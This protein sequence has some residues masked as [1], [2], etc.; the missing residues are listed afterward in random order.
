M[1]PILAPA[2]FLA[3]LPSCGTTGNAP[4]TTPLI[5][6]SVTYASAKLAEKRPVLVDDLRVLSV[7][8]DHLADGI[9]NRATVLAVLQKHLPAGDAEARALT[10]LVVG[11]FPAP[12]QA[13]PVSDKLKSLLKT[14][15]AAIR[16]GLPSTK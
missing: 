11:Y 5:S 13:F 14:V 12:E 15:A 16:F 2:A 3:F 1:K 8:L 9:V 7:E 4:D 10:S 6:V